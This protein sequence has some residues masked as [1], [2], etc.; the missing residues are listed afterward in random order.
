MKSGVLDM[1]N[2][3]WTQ[4]QLESFCATITADSTAWEEVFHDNDGGRQSHASTQTVDMHGLLNDLCETVSQKQVANTQTT[5]TRTTAYWTDTAAFLLTRLSL[6][7]QARVQLASFHGNDRMKCMSIFL[8][9]AH[10]KGYFTAITLDSDVNYGWT[11]FT[12]KKGQHANF[13]EELMQLFQVEPV[14]KNRARGWRK[15]HDAF[16]SFG[17]R[18]A[19]G[20][21]AYLHWQDAF[22]G[23]IPMVQYEGRPHRYVNH[24]SVQRPVF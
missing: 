18:P 14:N 13:G 21:A 1:M 20:T 8:H 2:N 5:N 15:I 17:L 19:K 23:K 24:S 22:E 16:I 4:E 6:D 9:Q 12:V 10:S 7:Q 3:V 11:G